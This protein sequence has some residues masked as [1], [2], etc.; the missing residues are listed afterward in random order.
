MW[1]RR[2]LSMARPAARRRWRCLLGVCVRKNF[3]AYR[4]RNRTRAHSVP[5]LTAP[6]PR[7]LR[8]AFLDRLRAA[9]GRFR[10]IP[11]GN[12]RPEAAPAGFGGHWEVLSAPVT[13]ALAE[14]I[15]TTE[16]L[17]VAYRQG[18][19]DLCAA[20]GL[21]SAMHRYGDASAATT[22]ATCAREAVK[23]HEIS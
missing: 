20:Y 5:S 4:P 9:G 17:E 8:R 18:A 6:P 11:T 12:A 3:K 16:C 15:P 10:H 7:A 23:F 1:K 22:I 21:A 13:S 14:V 19:A 2:P